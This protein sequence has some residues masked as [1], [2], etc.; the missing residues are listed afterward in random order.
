MSMSLYKPVGGPS[1]SYFI[2][3]TVINNSPV[4]LLWLPVDTVDI[5]KEVFSRKDVAF[6]GENGQV[7]ILDLTQL[8]LPE[9]VIM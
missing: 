4:P 5:S 1:R 8:N 6:G 9:T 3:G 2:Q 7:I